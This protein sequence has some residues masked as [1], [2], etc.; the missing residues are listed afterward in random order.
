MPTRLRRNDFKSLVSAP[1]EIV[2]AIACST[3]SNLKD[4]VVGKQPVIDGTSEWGALRNFLSK[5]FIIDIGMRIDMYQCDRT[6][7]F[8]HG[9]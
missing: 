2:C 1:I 6:M 5:H 8:R 7:L 4:L 3:Q 9:S